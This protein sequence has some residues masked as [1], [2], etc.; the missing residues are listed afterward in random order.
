[1][2]TVATAGVI[3]ASFDE[4]L[5]GWTIPHG[6]APQ[7]YVQYTDKHTHIQ[8]WNTS[9]HYICH[10]QTYTAKEKNMETKQSKR[11]ISTTHSQQTTITKAATATVGGSNSNSDNNN[12]SS[13]RNELMAYG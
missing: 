1:M 10:T 12:R 8:T 3:S 2:K 6:S 11:K 9:T 5:V 13:P 4:V 7:N